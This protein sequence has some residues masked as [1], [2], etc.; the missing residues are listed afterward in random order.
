LPLELLVALGR[1]YNA[2][3]RGQRLQPGRN[4]D[5][6]A[7]EIAVRADDD[8]TKIDAD[9]KANASLLRLRRGALRKR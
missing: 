9:A 1:N 8:I 2:S 4:V 6:V 3:R 7:I 5:T